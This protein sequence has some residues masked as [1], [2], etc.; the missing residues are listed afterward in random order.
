MDRPT[1][2]PERRSAA[3][4]KAP[5]NRTGRLCEKRARVKSNGSTRDEG[6]R[7][8]VNTYSP[9]EF[10]AAQA[11][12]TAQARKAIRAAHDAFGRP[13]SS[14]EKAQ[15]LRQK[16]SQARNAQTERIGCCALCLP[17]LGFS[18]SFRPCCALASTFAGVL[19]LSPLAVTSR[20]RARISYVGGAG[21]GCGVVA[22]VV[23][24]HSRSRIQLPIARGHRGHCRPFLDRA[25]ASAPGS[26]APNP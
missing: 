2:C 1:A 8:W 3:P 6:R 11:M 23:P 24:R 10:E 7:A 14:E 17:L 21:G 4:P 25:R 13:E 15:E 16:C 12:G 20:A 26:P 18:S 22:V 9:P 19:G 5:S